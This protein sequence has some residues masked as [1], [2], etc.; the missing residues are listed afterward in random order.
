MEDD[1]V[2][3]RRLVPDVQHEVGTRGRPVGAA[4][5]REED[6]HAAE[7]ADLRWHAER[8]RHGA[9]SR[10]VARPRAET[11]G[12]Y[13]RHWSLCGRS[14]SV[15]RDIWPLHAENSPCW[16]RTGFGRLVLVRALHA[17]P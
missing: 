4:R 3:S 14:G 1:A 11:T 7:L 13:S 9:T 2:Q 15:W 10:A 6:G 16:Q 17:K 5:R 12:G 8:R